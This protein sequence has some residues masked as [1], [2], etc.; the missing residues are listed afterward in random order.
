ML[1]L[2]GLEKIENNVLKAAFKVILDHAVP[3]DMKGYFS[4]IK[5]KD[6]IKYLQDS[7]MSKESIKIDENMIPTNEDQLQNLFHSQN[8]SE[9]WLDM[10]EASY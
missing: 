3:T 9:K 8:F 10:F 7:R 1:Q 5:W 2:A 4:I 6:S